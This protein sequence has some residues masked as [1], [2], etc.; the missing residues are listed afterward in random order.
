M[1]W[2]GVEWNEVQIATEIAVELEMQT[3]VQTE[4]QTDTGAV[5]DTEMASTRVG[6]NGMERN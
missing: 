5:V 3:E 1:K 2:S 4:V 6:T